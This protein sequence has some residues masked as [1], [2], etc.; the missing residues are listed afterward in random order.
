MFELKKSFYQNIINIISYGTY[1]EKYKYYLIFMIK[2]AVHIL[3][4]NSFKKKL[5]VSVLF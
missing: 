5:K 4:F 3:V 2:F 1:F